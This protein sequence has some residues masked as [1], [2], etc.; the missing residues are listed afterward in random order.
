MTR[1]P[2]AVPVT[3]IGRTEQ[4]PGFAR[5]V[6]EAVGLAIDTETV[7]RDPTAPPSVPPSGPSPGGA[8]PAARRE[9][10]GEA[11]EPGR[12]RVLSAATR[13]AD[14]DERAWVV[15]ARDVDPGALAAALD[16][17]T[18]D[19][20]NATFDARVTDRDVFGPAG[21][22]RHRG[23]R[24][25]DAQLADALLYAGLTGFGWYHGLAW[26]TERYLGVIAEGKGSVQLSY[27]AEAR[28]HRR[29]GRLRRRRRHRDA[30]GGGR[31]APTVG[32]RRPDRNGRARDRRPALPRPPLPLRRAARSGR[33]RRRPRAAAGGAAGLPHE[34]GR[35]DGGRPGQPVQPGRGAV[36]EPGLRA[37][38][39]GGAQPLGGRGGEG[40]AGPAGGSAPL[41][42]PHRSPR[43]GHAGRAG[44]AAGRG[45]GASSGVTPSC[46]DPTATTSCRCWAPT[47]AS[48]RST[49][50]S[51]G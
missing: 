4:L 10:I 1:D 35:A 40:A 23:I 33:L 48:I 42:G 30:V 25:W 29:A 8:V 21:Y 20:W 6:R 44:R 19:A 43:R 5:A 26:A 39:Q 2:R 41:A 49:C 17:V 18:A 51:S 46:W 22:G 32:R 15:D 50:R 12:M 14:G 34:P 16:G 24:W 11:G 38:G 7:Y 37:P 13:S 45:A 31:A 27:E 47:A 36:L 28:P 3:L 9:A